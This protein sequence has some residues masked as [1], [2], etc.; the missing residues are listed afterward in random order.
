[1]GCGNGSIVSRVARSD[2]AGCRRAERDG[3]LLA[4]RSD[5]PGP[6]PRLLVIAN[7]VGGARAARHDRRRLSGVLRVARRWRPGGGDKSPL[8]IAGDERGVLCLHGITGHAVRDPAARRG[9]GPAR[10][11]RGCA[12]AGGPRRHAAR[13]SPR[14][15]GATGCGRPRRRWTACRRASAAVPSRSAASRWAACWRCGWRGCYP[16]RISALVVMS[17]PLRLRRFQVAGHP[18][19]GAAP[20]RLPR[21]PGGGGAQARRARTSP[22][23]VFATRTPGCA[24]FRSPRSRRCWI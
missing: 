14:A 10:L 11:H 2:R 15:A 23:T 19:A 18:R 17:T 21:A 12:D 5:V 4:L 20:D 6:E 13:S 16:E 1:M 3:Q 8:S 7:S 9:A 24:R 22:T